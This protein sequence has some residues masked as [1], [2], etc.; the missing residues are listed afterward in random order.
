M[1]ATKHD[2]SGSLTPSNNAQGRWFLRV[3]LDAWRLRPSHTLGLTN[4]RRRDLPYNNSSWPK[5]N[6]VAAAHTMP[7]AIRQLSSYQH[8]P[9]TKENLDW[10][11]RESAQIGQ[12]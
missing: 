12:S 3:V 4:L 9:E 10:A 5:T 7:I 6:A 2:I 11:E 1:V 8:V